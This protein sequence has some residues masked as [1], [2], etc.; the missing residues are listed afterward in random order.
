MPETDDVW[1][2]CSENS[3]K[4]CQ[5]ER[6]RNSCFNCGRNH[7]TKLSHTSRPQR[8]PSVKRINQASFRSWYVDPKVTKIPNQI[9][10]IEFVYNRGVIETRRI[11]RNLFGWNM[12]CQPV[13]YN[14][15]VS[16]SWV[17]GITPSAP[18][19]WPKRRR[20]ALERLEPFKGETYQSDSYRDTNPGPL[21]SFRLIMGMIVCHTSYIK[22]SHHIATP[23]WEALQPRGLDW[24][25]KR[26]SL[27]CA[28]N[29]GVE[30]SRVETLETA[31]WCYDMLRC[32]CLLLLYL[33]SA[34]G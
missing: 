16:P 21:E 3:C 27:S 29:K 14:H 5:L 8:A 4:S 2:P 6:P 12:L 20:A 1:K 28:S 23:W 19:A 30:W 22:S 25:V 33:F 26:S 10:M 11:F 13:C 24:R 9:Q 18:M 7:S 32:W 15:T 31:R 34:E 17:A